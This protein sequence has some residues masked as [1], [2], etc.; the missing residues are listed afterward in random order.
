MRG[1]L[2]ELDQGYLAG[3]VVTV[4]SCLLDGAPPLPVVEHEGRRL[5][6]HLCDPRRNAHR[7]RGP[8]LAPDQP[9][10]KQVPFDPLAALSP[11]SLLTLEA[12]HD[13]DG[14]DPF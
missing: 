1:R 12:P 5:P 4:A 14:T 9:A 13:D 8:S 7:K 3:R 2:Y 11:S 10:R 6:L